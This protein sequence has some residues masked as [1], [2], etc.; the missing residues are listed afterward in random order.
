VLILD[1]NA[2]VTSKGPLFKKAW[3]DLYGGILEYRGNHSITKLDAA[4]QTVEFEFGD[5]V[6]ADVLNI[7]PGQKAGLIASAAGLTNVGGRWCGV[8]WKTMEST[9]HKNVHVLGDATSAT[10]GMPKSGHMTTQH[11]KVAAAAIVD[12]MSGLPAPDPMVIAN[13]C[14]SFV[15][16]KE[17]IHVAHPYVFNGKEFAV[18]KGAGGVSS[19]R[20]EPEAKYAIAWAK[21][22]WAD[23]LL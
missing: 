2:D 4:S 23:A 7:V 8:D 22:I 18:P 20:N 15:S 9:A 21:N 16:A 11:A 3:A 6:K 5:K 17:A 14:Y 1:A 13:T 10:A 19:A 12:L